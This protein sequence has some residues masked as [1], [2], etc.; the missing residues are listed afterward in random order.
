MLVQLRSQVE[1]RRLINNGYP[2]TGS[3]A[4]QVDSMSD[5]RS[6]LDRDDVSVT[7][8]SLA[9]ENG[10]EEAQTIDSLIEMG[11]DGKHRAV[12][13]IRS[14]RISRTVELKA[15]KGKVFDLSADSV[16]I[17][18]RFEDVL[19]G[20][21]DDVMIGEEYFEAKRDKTIRRI[22]DTIKTYRQKIEEL[23]A[24]RS[25]FTEL[26]EEN[27]DGSSIKYDL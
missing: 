16:T 17:Y 11:Y 20:D 22:D 7:K 1:A 12:T 8:V 10:E 18:S 24:A 13:S 25:D 19:S 15:K 9:R 4:V 2:R 26:T 5:M 6:I 14:P 27:W 23:E 3:R 21:V